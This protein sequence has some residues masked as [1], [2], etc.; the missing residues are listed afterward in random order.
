MENGSGTAA[1]KEKLEAQNADRQS[2]FKEGGISI[3]Q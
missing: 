2:Q 1:I 3:K